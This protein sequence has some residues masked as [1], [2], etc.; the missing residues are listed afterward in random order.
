MLN[1]LLSGV[2]NKICP[3]DTVI[4]AVS[5]GADS[6]ALLW[7][8]Y[9]LREQLGITLKAAHYNHGLRGAESDADA[10]FVAQFCSAYE[11]PLYMEKGQVISGPKGLEAAAREARYSFFDTLEGKIATAHTADDN[12]ETILM[13]LIRGT[14]LKGLGG[15]V[16]VRG[17]VIRPMLEIT[18][19]EVE[20]FLE[21]YSIS[22]VEDSSNA[23]DEFLRNRIRHHILPL[24]LRENPR[25]SLDLTAMA[26]GLRQDEAYLAEVTPDTVNVNELRDLPY[27]LQSRAIG[28]F[29]VNAGVAEPSRANINSVSALLYTDRPSARVD[30]PG[31]VVIQRTYDT[32]QAAPIANIPETVVLDCPGC[33]RFGNVVIHSTPGKMEAPRYERFVVKPEGQVVVRSRQSGD[34]MRLKGGTKSL[35]KLFTDRK[36][37]A[38]QRPYVPVIA[39]ER[40]VLGVWGFG[41]NLD[42][43]TAEGVELYLET[44]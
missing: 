29:L 1:K 32:L 28:R 36:I 18:R 40:G 34:E 12:A 13:H 22:H 27:A 8:M 31:G 4:C 20:A 42:R 44:L 16:P 10:A 41:A 33:V 6:M 2:R 38:S 30:L 17:N 24:L 25:L 23:G 7:G 37:P 35:K 43:V 3:G 15:I 11:I 5:G 26:A 21:E 14:G 19:R 39:D 9:L